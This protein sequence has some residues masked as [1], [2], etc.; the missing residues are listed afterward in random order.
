MIEVRGD[1]KK[2]HTGLIKKVDFLG[3]DRYLSYTLL[4][5]CFFANIFLMWSWYQLVVIAWTF[6]GFMIGRVLY[7]NDPYLLTHLTHIN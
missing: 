3:C 2:V 1:V 7:K 4:R 5:F 6:I